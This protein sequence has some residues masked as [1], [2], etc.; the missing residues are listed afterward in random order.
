MF[1]SATIA[2][3]FASLLQQFLV[4]PTCVMLLEYLF[5]RESEEIMF[6]KM[7]F[8]PPGDPDISSLSK[9]FQVK[10]DHCISLW[11]I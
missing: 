7:C 10:D 9:T 5:Q 3:T 11:C 6:Q 8:K 4:L 1:L 2:H